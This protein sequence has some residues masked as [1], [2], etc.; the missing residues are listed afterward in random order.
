MLLQ[1]LLVLIY[2]ITIPVN[3]DQVLSSPSP[4]K[5]IEDEALRKD[6]AADVA[7]DG[8]HMLRDPPMRRRKCKVSFVT[9][10]SNR[11]ILSRSR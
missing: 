2:N 3:D 8:M 6:K 9:I 7:Y 10:Y 5:G 11:L 1:Y 4:I